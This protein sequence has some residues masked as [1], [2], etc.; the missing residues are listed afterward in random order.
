LLIDE[1][2]TVIDE[3]SDDMNL[4]Q[5]KPSQRFVKLLETPGWCNPIFGLMRA[6]VLAKTPL[7][8][9][10]PRSDRNLLAEL[11][12]RGEFLELPEYLFRRRV[13]PEISTQAH[14]SENALAEWFDTRHKGKAVYPRWRRYSDYVAMIGRTPLTMSERIL[15]YRYLSRFL[16]SA[17]KIGALL[18]DIQQRFMIRRPIADS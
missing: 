9:N 6:D 3:Y 11:S 5:V 12:L 14:T 1:Y 16:F 15:L 2:G 10:Y 7:I 18:A 17:G 13:H 4:T 8:G